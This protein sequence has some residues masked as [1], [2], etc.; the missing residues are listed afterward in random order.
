MM[1]ENIARNVVELTWNTKI[2][3]IVHLVDYFHSCITMHGFMNIR[4]IEEL[5]LSDFFH[6]LNTVFPYYPYLNIFAC[7]AALVF[8][9]WPLTTAKVFNFRPVNV[10]PMLETVSLG[11]VCLRVFPFFLT[12]S[13]HQC[14]IF[15]FRLSTTDAV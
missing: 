5:C 8:S 9:L 2:I 3:Y 11:P 7:T 12:I 13:F 15:N 6:T 4:T 1:D 10:G 14:S